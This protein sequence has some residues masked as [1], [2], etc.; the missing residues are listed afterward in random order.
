MRGVRGYSFYSEFFAACFLAVWEFL[1]VWST[2]FFAPAIR[3]SIVFLVLLRRSA[4]FFTDKLYS[5]VRLSTDIPEADRFELFYKAIGLADLSEI[6]R[7]AHRLHEQ[8][9]EGTR[10]LENEYRVRRERVAHVISDLSE[11]RILASKSAGSDVTKTQRRLAVLAALPVDL[12]L[13]QLST[14]AQR[15]TAAEPSAKTRPTQAGII[16]I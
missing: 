12:P 11:T 7:R 8:L 10:Q 4:I 5:I 16:A 1:R 13:A 15:A 9:R 6:G 2:F 14:A 3:S